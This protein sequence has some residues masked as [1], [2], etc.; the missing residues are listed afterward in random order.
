MND[1]FTQVDRRTGYSNLNYMH[2]PAITLFQLKPS[3]AVLL[4]LY[5]SMPHA[6]NY[7]NLYTPVTFQVGIF[8]NTKHTQIVKDLHKA[9]VKIY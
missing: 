2:V 7:P 8:T 3:N 9:N 4:N 6:Q 1:G 5:G